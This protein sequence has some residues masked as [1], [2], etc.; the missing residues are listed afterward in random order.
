MI[1]PLISPALFSALFFTFV[2]SMTAISAVIF[3]VSGRWNL[4][5]IGILGSVENSDLSQAAAYSTVLILIVLAAMVALR[6]ITNILSYR[7][8]LLGAG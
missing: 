2:K 5:T 7:R 1:L 4:V 3:V 8:R 6:K